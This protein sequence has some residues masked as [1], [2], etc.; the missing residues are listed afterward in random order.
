[1]AVWGVWGWDQETVAGL[2]WWDLGAAEPPG[3]TEFGSGTG[4]FGLSAYGSGRALGGGAG[5]GILGLV[6]RGAGRALTI[7]A[8]A[9]GLLGVAATG[10]GAVAVRGRGTSVL[11][12]RGG[13]AGVV[14]FGPVYRGIICPRCGYRQ[15]DMLMTIC[16]RCNLRLHG[17]TEDRNMGG[18]FFG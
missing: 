7:G 6:A 3:V 18:R 9:G 5:V 14:V 13:G 12:V 1:M 16:S 10:A 17:I 11:W 4:V 15:V 2:L 8:G